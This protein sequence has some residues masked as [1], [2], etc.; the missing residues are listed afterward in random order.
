MEKNELQTWCI[1][2][3]TFRTDKLNTAKQFKTHY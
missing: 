1:R 3:A 2:V